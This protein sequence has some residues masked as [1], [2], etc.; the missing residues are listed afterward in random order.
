MW[1]YSC[2]KRIKVAFL[3]TLH[4]RVA[5]PSASDLPGSAEETSERTTSPWT[6]SWR[7]MEFVSDPYQILRATDQ[8]GK[9]ARA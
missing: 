3:F 6:A 4:P 2:F 8:P 7:P 1:I 9:F 5:Q